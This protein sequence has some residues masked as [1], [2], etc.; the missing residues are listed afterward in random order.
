MKYRVL[1]KTGLE[2]SVIGMGTD[3]F[4]GEWGQNFSQPVIDKII[5]K[6]HELGINFIDTAECYGDHLSESFVGNAIKKREDWIIA[7]KFGH[8]YHGFQKQRTTHF[9]VKGIEEQLENSLKALKTDYIDFYQFHSPTNEEFFNEDVWAFLEKKI[10][11]GKIRHIGIALI[12][13]AVNEDD[14]F[15][16]NQAESAKVD[17]FQIVYNR[18]NKKA[19][20]KVLPFC[21]KNNFGVLARIPLARGH[22]T[23]KYTP[24]ATF[25]SNDR[26]SFENKEQTIKQLEFVQTLK[27]NEV[28]PN[29]NMA[30]WALS[31]CLQNSIISA[32]IPGMKNLEQVELNAKAA[33]LDF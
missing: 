5:D 12:A 2:T 22:L 31:W 19:E 15:Q 14:M 16:L 21:Q 9:N 29:V 8:K 1:G 7:T 26:R 33:D 23:G 13:S 3:Q 24:D 27:E 18:I 17:M 30:Q 6:A 11:E 32:V 4:Y 28:P 10:S 20:E 25:P